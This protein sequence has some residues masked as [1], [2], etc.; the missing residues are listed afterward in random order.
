[1][2]EFEIRYNA[3]EHALL[4]MSQR[5]ILE[6][7]RS[8]GENGAAWIDAFRNAVTGEISDT[9]Q[10]GDER[11]V[12]VTKMARSVVEG[13][14]SMAKHRYELLREEGRL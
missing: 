3:M 10:V 9:R 11:P 6:V 14:T 1:M 7:A 5:L 13:V 2:E 8:K 12:A 4:M